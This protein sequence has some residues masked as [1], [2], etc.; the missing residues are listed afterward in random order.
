M[1]QDK[2]HPRGYVALRTPA[3]PSIDGRL[4]EATWK[5]AAWSEPFLDIVGPSGPKP[6]AQARVKMMWDTDALYIGAALEDSS[7]FANKTL[8]DS[9]IYHDNNFEVDNGGMSL[10][11]LDAIDAQGFGSGQTVLSSAHTA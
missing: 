3:A 9:I 10:R 4:D 7:L 11:E 1:P 2:P 8:H 5:A 6:W